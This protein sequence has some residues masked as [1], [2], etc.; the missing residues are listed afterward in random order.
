[1]YGQDT[2]GPIKSIYGLN[3]LLYNGKI[4]KY[5][6][7]EN[8]DGNQYLKGVDFQPGSAT[9]KG[10][11]YKNLLLNYDVYNQK[12]ILKFENE[13]RG[14]SIIEVSDAW[15]EKFALGKQNFKII[16]DDKNINHIYQVF[17]TDSIV[18]LYYWRKILTLENVTSTPNYKFLGPERKSMV[19]MNHFFFKYRNNRGFLRLF[20][21]YKKAIFKKYLHEHRINLK[22]ANDNEIIEF[23]NFCNNKPIR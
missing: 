11:E 6:V 2:V 22:K 12:L 5:F 15:L 1:M 17:G 16:A 18:I 23:V 7:P 21:P 8:V 19:Y 13:E 3:P 20:D 10:I 4:Y 14:K 9:L